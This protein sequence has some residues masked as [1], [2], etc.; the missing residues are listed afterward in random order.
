MTTPFKNPTKEEITEEL[1]TATR[2]FEQGP[3]AEC[4]IRIKCK[5]CGKTLEEDELDTTGNCLRCNGYTGKI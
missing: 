2:Y 3:M 5:C 1:Q 4:I